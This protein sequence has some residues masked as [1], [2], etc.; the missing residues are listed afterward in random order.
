MT[1]DLDFRNRDLF[2]PVAF[3]STF[4]NFEDITSTQ[5]WSLFFTAGQNDAALGYNPALGNFFNGLLIAI[6]ATGIVGALIFHPFV[7]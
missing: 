4:N 6:A 7:N 3:R 1:T 5:A 2:G